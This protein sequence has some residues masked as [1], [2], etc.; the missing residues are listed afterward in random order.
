MMS[1]E[2]TT[3]TAPEIVCGGC[4]NAIKNAFGK[5]EGV[6]NVEVDVASKQVSVE[7][8]SS[9]T[10]EDIVRVLEEAGFAGE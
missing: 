7:H 9:V 2:R 8:G 10:R 4:A 3:V 1:K 6:S 5:L